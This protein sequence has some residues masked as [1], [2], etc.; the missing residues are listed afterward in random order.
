[1]NSFGQ[2]DLVELFLNEVSRQQR[3]GERG[4]SSGVD[5]KAITGKT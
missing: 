1:M 2:N 3:G 4:R 5:Y